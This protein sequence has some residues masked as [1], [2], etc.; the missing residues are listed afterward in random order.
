MPQVSASPFGAI[1]AQRTLIFKTLYPQ[2]TSSP[3]RTTTSP[4]DCAC[5]RG[6]AW[7]TGA[8]HNMVASMERQRN[9]GDSSPP[10]NHP[11]FHFI[12]S[13]LRQLRC[14]A[15]PTGP[16]GH[17]QRSSIEE[18]GSDWSIFNPSVPFYVPFYV[19]HFL[20]C[21]IL[22]ARRFSAFILDMAKVR[23]DISFSE[24]CS[25][26]AANTSSGA[27]VMEM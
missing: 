8:R 19:S 12:P 17:P 22:I 5:G 26:S 15:A 13:G 1:C 18:I 6:G 21:L 7:Y 4:W 27:C 14:S 24:K 10:P 11:G 9:R 16:E 25:V 3:R 2:K 20:Y 23:S